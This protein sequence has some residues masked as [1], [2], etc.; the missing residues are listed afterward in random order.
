[1]KDE[2]N[3]PVEPVRISRAMLKPPSERFKAYA[4][5]LALLIPAVGGLVFGVV[6]FI[7]GDSA[8]D[9]IDQ[10]WVLL[11]K[12]VDEQSHRLN[13]LQISIVEMKAFV[14]GKSSGELHAE[15]KALKKENVDLRARNR[16]PTRVSRQ[17]KTPLR[18]KPVVK[19]RLPP[20][21]QAVPQQKM[22]APL[23]RTYR[24]GH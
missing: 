12:K 10:Q 19:Y 15:L 13:N 3:T 23:P 6:G 7:K 24:K 20:Q 1:M 11:K 21:I 8:N 17:E 9:G 4:Q 22:I 16:R 14:D 5:G 2:D 18:T